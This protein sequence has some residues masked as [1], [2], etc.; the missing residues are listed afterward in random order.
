MRAWLGIRYGFSFVITHESR[1]GAGY[2]GYTGYT[3]SWKNRA[4]DIALGAAYPANR[5]DGGP[6]THFKDAQRA[7]EVTLKQLVKRN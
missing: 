4:L 3:A 1:C 7:C 5:I 6:W 2:E